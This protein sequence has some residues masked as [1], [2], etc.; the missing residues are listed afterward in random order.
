MKNKGF[1]LI[2]LL[3]VITILGVVSM[4]TMPALIKYVKDAQNS[5]DSG[6]KSLIFSATTTYLTEYQDAYP[7]D[8]GNNYCI[9]INEDLIS[10]G[11]LDNSN[12]EKYDFETENNIVEVSVNEN[13]YNY[14]LGLST[15]CN[16]NYESL[17]VGD[18]VTLVDNSNWHV[19]DNANYNDEYV[20]LFSDNLISSTNPVLSYCINV[21]EDANESTCNT[22]VFDTIA[23]TTYNTVSS[24]NIGYALQNT[25]RNAIIESISD[26]GGITTNL[27][28]GLITMNDLY[29][30]F[31]TGITDISGMMHTANWLRSN[32]YWTS[33]AE[34]SSYVFGVEGGELV[35][36]VPTE[37]STYGIRPV[38]TILKSNIISKQKQG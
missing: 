29:K 27:T 24:T 31:P 16:P 34:S 4:I 3:G 14:E 38:I 19:L 32:N 37:A 22:A 2:E 28:I 30:F 9:Y 7:K 8:N 17:S 20:R 12:F 5:I 1:T 36:S 25:Y 15:D 13:Q 23:N 26:S 6:T 35:T 33:V 21:E 18:G 10:N 11:I